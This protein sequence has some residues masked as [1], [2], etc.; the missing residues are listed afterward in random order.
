L[1]I[2]SVLQCMYCVCV[3]ACVYIYVESRLKLSFKFMSRL[4]TFW[5][6]ISLRPL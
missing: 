1:Y 3:R 4:D 5:R 2:I 6:L